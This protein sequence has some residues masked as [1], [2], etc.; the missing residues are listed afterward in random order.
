MLFTK[1]LVA[2]IVIG[3]YMFSC[4]R[5]TTD[6]TE[7][8]YS[9]LDDSLFADLPT[10]I[11]IAQNVNKSTLLLKTGSLSVSKSNDRQIKNSITISDKEHKNP[12]FYAINYESGGFAI[13][14]A[15]KRVMPILGFSDK[16]KFDIDSIPL[17]MDKWFEAN[18]SHIKK[19][20]EQKNIPSQVISYAWANLACPVAKTYQCPPPVPPEYSENTV[21]VGP[22]LATT[23]DQGCGYN[24]NCPALTGGQCGHAW[25]GCVNTAMAQ[26]M[27]FW[28]YPSSFSWSAMSN[29]S[30]NSYV[31]ALMG[32]IFPHVIT[33]YDVNGSGDESASSNIVSTFKTT[34]GY[35]SAAYSG[36]SL[37]S[38]NTLRTYLGYHQPIILMGCANHSSILGIINKYWN[39][40]AWV[41]DGYLETTYYH[42]G[43]ETSQTLYFDM[44]W[45]WSGS[46]NGWYAFD[47]WSNPL[48][49][50]QYADAF[51]YNI[52]P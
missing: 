4:N 5:E 49:N 17:G 26:V 41:C 21:T 19:L 35:S 8:I 47:N 24:A 40:H 7:F 43:T 31:A 12:Y 48:A 45:G 44:N 9:A 14:S 28:Q 10:A 33:S 13:I 27:R 39:C 38:Y 52:H 34:Y 15:D 11:D 22:L 3:I 46:Y 25:T 16:G 1:I 30:G 2:G 23:W 51:V 20:R 50:F 32:S 29:S 36:Y 18:A 37:S 42:N 6:P